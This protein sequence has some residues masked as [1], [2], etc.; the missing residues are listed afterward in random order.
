MEYK[1][2]HDSGAALLCKHD[3]IVEY[4]DAAEVRVRRDNGA[5]DVY[6]VTKFVVQTQEPATTNVH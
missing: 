2:A 1:S 3:G 6:S 5:L 4:V